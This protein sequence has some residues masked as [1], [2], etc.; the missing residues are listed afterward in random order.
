MVR[1][2]AENSKAP[3]LAGLCCYKLFF[4]KHLRIVGGVDVHQI[5]FRQL[6]YQLISYIN[7]SNLYKYE[8]VLVR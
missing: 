1:R 2:E 4:N 5:D 3:Q 6:S 8:F 7:N